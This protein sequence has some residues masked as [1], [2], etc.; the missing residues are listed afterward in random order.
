MQPG[1]DNNIYVTTQELYIDQI[2]NPDVWG[3]V[4][5]N[6]YFINS[7]A[8]S[9]S[10]RTGVSIPNFIDARQPGPA[11]PDFITTTINCNT[12]AFETRCLDRFT[13]TW[14]FGD[15]TPP[16][17][18]NSVQHQFLSANI[19]KVQL[20]L[21]QGSQVYGSITK[22]ITVLPLSA[23]IAGPQ[24]VCTNSVYLSQYSSPVL[25]DVTYKWTAIGGSLSGPD[26]LYYANVNWSPANTTGTVQ[27]SVSRQGCTLTSNK[28]VNISPG[29]NFSWSLPDSICLFDSALVLSA[30][31]QSGRYTGKGISGNRFSPK[32]AGLGFHTITYRYGDEV[33]CQGQ[34]DKIIKVSRCNEPIVANTNCDEVLNSVRLA[35]N[36][37]GNVLR[38]QSPFALGFIQVFNASGQ[39]VAKGNLVNNSLP[40]PGLAAGIYS[41]VVFCKDGGAYKAVTFVKGR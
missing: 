4:G 3:G 28:L 10:I 35:P 20:T 6:A 22:P 23:T 24:S 21:T 13:A 32:E 41:V 37:T 15:G 39:L 1:P 29:P 18:G 7:R 17:T 26:N 30:S 5:L 25:G 16:V 34:I 36:P 19:F 14:N 27:L 38:L 31:P 2:T 33:T 8:L 40:L 9:D 11:A 12:I